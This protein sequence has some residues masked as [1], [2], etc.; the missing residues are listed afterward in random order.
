MTLAALIIA[1]LP[2]KRRLGPQDLLPLALVAAALSPAPA[3][4]AAGKDSEPE[5]V[6]ADGGGDDWILDQRQ[7]HTRAYTLSLVGNISNTRAGPGL[8]YD[9]P[10][11]HDGI[12]PRLNDSI[13]IELGADYMVDF[14][15]HLQGVWIGV[16]PRWDLYLTRTWQIF[17]AVKLGIF[18]IVRTDGA[19]DNFFQPGLSLGGEYLLG[20]AVRLRLEGG[21]PF[22]V[23]IGVTFAPG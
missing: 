4:A 3:H 7:R 13:A 21:W 17:A 2:G 12:L 11:A 9:I 18:P 8:W 14:S 1:K 19:A 15:R 6:A 22:G 23:R 20:H 5:A 10:V 16:G